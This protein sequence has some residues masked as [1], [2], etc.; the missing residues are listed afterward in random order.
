MSN[1]VQASVI[2]GFSI[3]SREYDASFEY[4]HDDGMKDAAKKLGFSPSEVNEFAKEHGLKIESVGHRDVKVELFLC[5][6]TLGVSASRSQE[7]VV[8]S[9]PRVPEDDAFRKLRVL[10]KSIDKEPQWLALAY[11][12]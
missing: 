10:G 7:S 8:I 5:H 11:Y 4:L 1:S 9:L 3:G 12:G 6:P 2:Y